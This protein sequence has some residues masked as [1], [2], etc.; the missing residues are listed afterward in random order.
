V[1]AV[2]KADGYG[3]GAVPVARTLVDAGC[4][5]L[6]VAT[7][8]E[9][10]ELR[11]GGV[12]GPVLLLEGLHHPGDADV[13]LEL[14]TTPVI[15]RAD[16]FL[17]LDAAAARA[18]RNWPIQLK[19]DTGMSRLGFAASELTAALDALA[20]C[21]RLSCEGVMSHLAD[22]DDVKAASLRRQRK[23]FEAIVAGLRARGISPEWVHL[24]NSAGILHGP[25]PGTSAVRPGIWL[26]GPDPGLE[27]GHGLEPVM[28]LVT[29]V[30]HAK[31]VPA[32]TAVGYGG[33]YKTSGDTNVLTLPIGYAD[34]LPRSAGGRFDVGWRDKR[35]P[36]VGRISMDLATVDAGPDTNILVGEEI[37]I[38]GRR[39]GVEIRVEELAEAV[40][41]IA[42]EILVGISPRV[43]RVIND[44]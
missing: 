20:V 2:V 31:P 41:T 16:A 15:G 23:D 39:E 26:Y 38:F 22:A 28:T 34:G 37:L 42:Y 33:T 4:E 6:A 17:P 36:L 35:V 43:P 24:D 21:S 9:A 10:A 19:F 25:S 29:R 7:L 32:G 40:D 12:G 8:E 13:A 44:A 1:I 30:L 27:G 11:T 5:A 18:G 3:H 14:D